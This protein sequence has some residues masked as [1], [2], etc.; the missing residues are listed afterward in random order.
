VLH[1]IRSCLKMVLSISAVVSRHQTIA[2]DRQPL[3]LYCP[4][5]GDW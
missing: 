2:V 5:T 1:A 4:S 3:V